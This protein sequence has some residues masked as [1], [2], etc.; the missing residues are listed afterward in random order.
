MSQL[1]LG[2][3][4][5]AVLAA[6]VCIGAAIAGVLPAV[7]D[8]ERGDVAAGREIAIKECSGC[9]S[10][11]ARERALQLFDAPGF[12]EVAANPQT[13]AISLRAFLQSSHPTM[14][15]FVLTEPERDNIIAYILSLRQRS[16]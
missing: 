6:A 15:N 10:L 14:P 12:D 16:L 8:E 4:G 11:S 3:K 1:S 7:A 5:V 13:T 9:H 2:G